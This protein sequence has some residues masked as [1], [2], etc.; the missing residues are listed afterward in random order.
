[1]SL[2]KDRLT[3]NHKQQVLENAMSYTAPTSAYN[4]LKSFTSVFENVQNINPVEEVELE[5]SNLVNV[6]SAVELPT[7]P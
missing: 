4:I 1:M 7:I 2:I 5:A 3:A 6:L